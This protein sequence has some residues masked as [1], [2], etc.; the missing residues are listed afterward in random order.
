MVKIRPLSPE[1]VAQMAAGEVIDS[2]EA[3]LRELIENALDA[4]ASRVQ[5][6]LWP[7]RWQV[8][9]ADNGQGIPGSELE[10]VARRHTTSKWDG[11]SLGFRG[12]RKSTRLNSSHSR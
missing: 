10:Q 6:D 5:V 7:S 1:R 11:C 8:R 9:V 2:L 3:A 12:D 4:Q